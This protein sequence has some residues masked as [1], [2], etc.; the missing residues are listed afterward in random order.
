LIGLGDVAL[1]RYD[2][3]SAERLLLEG[4]RQAERW[5]LIS[6][7]NGYLS[8][9]MLHSI[10]GDTLALQ[11]SLEML[12]DLAQRFDASEFDDWIV[13]LFEAGIKV[14]NGDLEAVRAWVARRDLEDAPERIPSLY[15]Q[16]QVVARLYKYELPILARMCIA[17]GRYERAIKVLEELRSLAERANRPFLQ[18]EAEILKSRAFH[19]MD[20][21]DS[22]LAALRRAL[23]MA[24]P[25][26]VARVFLVEGE[27]FIRFIQ[28]ARSIWDS[29]ELIEF[30]DRLLSKAGL[31]ISMGSPTAQDLLEPLSPR[32]LEVLHLLPTGLTAEELAGELIVS[33]NTVR[34]HM[35]SIYAKLGVHSRHEAVAKATE[36]DLL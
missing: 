26:D 11:D 35:K 9:A 21:S 12:H 22:S 19:A 27:E 5:S 7:L 36:L 32:E 4:I 34:S 14:R 6:T 25:V 3:I 8:M 28:A 10:R 16:D 15:Q 17:E 18:I 2:L 31:P 24:A 33:V 30:T 13:E 20:D 29:H 23:Q 1:E